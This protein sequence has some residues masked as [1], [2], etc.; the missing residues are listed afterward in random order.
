M[1]TATQL[2]QRSVPK[3]FSSAHHIHILSIYSRQAHKA[4][5]VR[6]RALGAANNGDIRILQ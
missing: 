3:A 6:S 5:T 4:Q 2:K 1:E